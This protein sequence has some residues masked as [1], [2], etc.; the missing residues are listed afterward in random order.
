M[1]I[2]TIRLWLLFLFVAS[3]I[4]HFCIFTYTYFEKMIYAE[5][6]EALTLLILA[7]YSI[8]LGVILGG[9]F[10]QGKQPE[11]RAVPS[12]FYAAFVLSILWNALLIVRTMI[13][14]FAKEDFVGDVA[15]FLQNTS[16]GSSFLIAGALAF[17][18]AKK[19]EDNQYAQGKS[20]KEQNNTTS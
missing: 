8:P 20:T 4:L 17:F 18:F 6:F 11:A 5:D 3:L 16:A 19:S 7:I 13:F 15:D 10:A 12:A 2:S 1:R 9:F 14:G